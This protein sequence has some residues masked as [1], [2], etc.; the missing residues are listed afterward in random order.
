MSYKHTPRHWYRPSFEAQCAQINEQRRL[1]RIIEEEQER[2]ARRI[3]PLRVILP[4]G[5]Y[6]EIEWKSYI[7]TDGHPILDVDGNEIPSTRDLVEGDRI[8][9]LGLIG[10]WVHCRVEIVNDSLV[11]FDGGNIWWLK[12]AHDT[13]RCWGGGNLRAVQKME[14]A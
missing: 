5:P 1:E 13:W 7:D 4:K 11:G 10:G 8:R 2:A 9:V 14:L 12:R 6:P 3:A